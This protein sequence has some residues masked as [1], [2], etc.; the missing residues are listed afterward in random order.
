MNNSR[1][2]GFP[3]KQFDEGE[4]TDCPLS[5]ALSHRLSIGAPEF[6]PSFLNPKL[7]SPSSG[8]DLR[9]V[10]D[11]Y[12]ALAPGEIA[13]VAITQLPSSTLTDKNE[14]CLRNKLNLMSDSVPRS[15]P[16]EYP[17]GKNIIENDIS[18]CTMTE[19]RNLI[20]FDGDSLLISERSAT[21]RHHPT[22]QHSFSS[23]DEQQSY[24]AASSLEESFPPE[25]DEYA[26]E[27]QFVSFE[28]NAHFG[29]PFLSQLTL[30]DRHSEN[31]YESLHNAPEDVVS[32][33]VQ[34]YEQEEEASYQVPAE[35]RQLR[36]EI[37]SAR[38]LFKT[39]AEA[40][41]FYYSLLEGESR[42]KLFQ[43]SSSP[44]I[45][46]IQPPGLTHP[47]LMHTSDRPK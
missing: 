20:S 22:D 39:Y 15:R 10:P 23:K 5:S 37:P 30:T 13:Q 44:Q 3:S 35:T 32:G 31:N 38:P 28:Q 40:T 8:P 2:E 17:A 43:D 18:S 24:T 9:L 14:Q 25:R 4:D 33:G 7:L 34:F 41:N 45:P 27:N 11:P 47:S 12:L 19:E 36:C 42:E 16:Q 6:V 26:K 1:I 29:V 46:P 21:P